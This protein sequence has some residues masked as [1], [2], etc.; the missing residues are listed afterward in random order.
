[1]RETTERPEAVAAGTVKLV[2][3]DV[4]TIV[5]EV[6]RLMD[7]PNAYDEMS[8][9]HNPYGDGRA[10]KRIVEFIAKYEEPTGSFLEV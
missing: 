3:T 7:D 9:A 8:H 2:G 5:R 10:S 4:D 6:T 1:M